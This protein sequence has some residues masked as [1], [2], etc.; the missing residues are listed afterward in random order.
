[1]AASQTVH[2]L[3][4]SRNPSD[5]LRATHSAKNGTILTPRHGVATLF[6]YGIKVRVDRGHLILEDGIGADRQ[7]AG[8]P[9]VGHDL[10]RLVIIGSDGLISLAA[11]R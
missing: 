4:N 5:I 7:V 11:L 3:S 8:V 9:R 10:R 6:G 1:M 2:H